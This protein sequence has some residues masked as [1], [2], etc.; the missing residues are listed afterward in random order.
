MSKA[1]K[2]SGIRDN[3]RDERQYERKKKGPSRTA[4]SVNKRE[5]VVSIGGKQNK[6]KSFKLPSR[7]KDLLKE[8]Q[9]D[10]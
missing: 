10:D 2:V 8:D 9:A 1:E 5:N 3:K 4:S 7:I 6:R